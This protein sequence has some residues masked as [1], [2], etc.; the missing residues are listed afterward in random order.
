MEK[1]SIKFKSTG[2]ILDIIGKFSEDLIDISIS[3]SY[4]LLLTFYFLLLTS[5]FLLL[6]SYFL[7]FTFKIKWGMEAL[8]ELFLVSEVLE[9][10]KKASAESPTLSRP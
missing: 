8:F 4:F 9:V 2:E 1:D 6:T 7:L 5:Y 10:T 3:T